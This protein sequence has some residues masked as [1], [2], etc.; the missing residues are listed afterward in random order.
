MSKLKENHCVNNPQLLI[1]KYLYEQKSIR[2]IA[3][4]IKCSTDTV[5]NRLRKYGVQTRKYGDWVGKMEKCPNW[6]GG[7]YNH[8]GYILVRV[9]NHPRASNNGYVREH[10]LVWEK[11]HKKSLLKGWTI[12]HL[13]GIRDDN[14]IENLEAMSSRKHFQLIPTFKKRIFE[15]E[16][17]LFEARLGR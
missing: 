8:K 16:K 7:R 17:E 11:Y 2:K 9:P 14:R 10:I 6:R 3:E 4:E 12:H 13:N 15:L 5:L 1:R